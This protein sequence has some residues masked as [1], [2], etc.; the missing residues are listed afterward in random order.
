M[1]SAI[2]NAIGRGYSARAVLGAI[3]RRAPEYSRTINEA[4]YTGY[5][6]TSILRSLVNKMEGKNYDED[7]FLTAR[8]RTLKNDQKNKTRA[9]TQAV[10][11]MGT[12]GAVAAGAYALMER[13]KP[14]R[15]ELIIPPKDHKTK[16]KNQPTI[17]QNRLALPYHQKQITST[18]NKQIA[19]HPERKPQ[20]QPPIITPPI[21]P[22][23]QQSNQPQQNIP[24]YNPLSVDIVK[25]LREDQRFKNIIEAGYDPLVTTQ[26]LRQIIPKNIL[27]VLEKAEGGLE[28]LVKDYSGYL[29]DSQHQQR[30]MQQQ[31][32]QKQPQFNPG[33][34]AYDQGGQAELP[35][36]QNQQM[37]Q[38]PK[39]PEQQPIPQQMQPQQRAP[40]PIAPVEQPQVQKPS[41][42]TKP[43]VSF[44]NG[45][46]G[47]LEGIEKGVASVNIDGNIV[48]DKANQLTIEGPEAE[49]A[50]R[51]LVNAIPEG[52]KSTAIMSATYIP[53]YEMAV[54]K[55]WSGE[56]AWFTGLPEHDYE[57]IALG[58]YTPKGE[59]R[60]GI[61][62]YKPSV[63][64]SHG[65]A[66]HELIVKNPRF[67]KE[68]KG[69]TW[70]YAKNEFDLLHGMQKHLLKYSK[71]RYDKEGNLI[72]SKRKKK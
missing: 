50:S 17:E 15:T 67:S 62:E 38:Q 52:M 11:A 66:N 64:D 33:K 14:P 55:Y 42:Q 1:A 31:Q 68:N 65:A 10:A 20:Q 69:K 2:F 41:A 70:G 35:R 71:E 57:Q 61:A 3:G 19:H 46:I 51:Q 12:A 27:P 48:K 58:T 47:T 13:N 36:M 54:L 30:E 45:K 59:A 22:Q 25:N 18:Q 23:N 16:G 40:E 44:K 26:I 32:L 34:E 39:A 29:K 60:T 63:G 9:Y 5:T 56:T 72:T 49:N 6:A 7:R 53:Q 37:Q 24:S 21:P 4:Y 43:L 28:Q 8:E